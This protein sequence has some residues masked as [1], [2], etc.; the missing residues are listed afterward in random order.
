MDSLGRYFG[1]HASG[2]MVNAEK[3]LSGLNAYYKVDK[4]EDLFSVLCC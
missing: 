4:V 2:D 1:E 3:D